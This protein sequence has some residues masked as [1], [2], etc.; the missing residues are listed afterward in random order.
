MGNHFPVADSVT[1][2]VKQIILQYFDFQPRLLIEILPSVT[3]SFDSLCLLNQSQILLNTQE[4]KF[5]LIL[6]D[7]NLLT[8]FE[9][10][11]G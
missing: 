6:S 4:T 9:L 7:S 1:L 5:H 8:L 2:C 10:A 11:K 3:L